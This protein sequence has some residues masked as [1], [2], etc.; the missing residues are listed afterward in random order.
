[1]A[2][3][4]FAR[5]R[6]RARIPPVGVAELKC[7]WSPGLREVASPGIFSLAVV[8]IYPCSL[9]LTFVACALRDG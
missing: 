4:V 5:L 7:I 2:R 9:T 8:G 3:T 6:V 1:M